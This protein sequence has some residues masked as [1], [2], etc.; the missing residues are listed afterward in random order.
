MADCNDAAAFSFVIVASRE[1]VHERIE[2]TIVMPLRMG[3]P[4]RNIDVPQLRLARSNH[5]RE[6]TIGF[7]PCLDT[8][9]VQLL[10]Q[11]SNRLLH[12]RIGLDLMDLQISEA[13]GE[14]SLGVEIGPALEP[15]T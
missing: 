3:L 14:C 1:I 2:R 13:L 11:Q 15:Q 7:E 4:P 12:R 6:T 8:R 10:H 9:R 5:A